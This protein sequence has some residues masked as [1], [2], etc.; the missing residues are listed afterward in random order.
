MLLGFPPP[1]PPMPPRSLVRL[2]P[3]AR[4]D[5]KTRSLSQ[6]NPPR[7]APPRHLRAKAPT[8]VRPRNNTRNATPN[9]PAG[10]AAAHDSATRHRQKSYARRRRR[11]HYRPR[12][13]CVEQ[14]HTTSLPSPSHSNI[15]D[16]AIA[17][18][19]PTRPLARSR[20]RSHTRPPTRPTTPHH[21]PRRHGPRAA[22]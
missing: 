13:A 6:R 7:S 11:P 5:E 14:T 21:D 22:T 19:T 17:K 10:P 12:S 18:P 4:A 2:K 20:S 1:V 8:R 3:K 16:V 15:P 9:S